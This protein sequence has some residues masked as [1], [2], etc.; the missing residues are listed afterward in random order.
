MEE[1][2]VPEISTSPAAMAGD[3]AYS[4]RSMESRVRGTMSIQ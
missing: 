1:Y 4:D 2:L 3:I